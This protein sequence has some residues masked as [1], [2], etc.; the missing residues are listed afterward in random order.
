M[1]ATWEQPKKLK[2]ADIAK[3]HIFVVEKTRFTN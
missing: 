3:T 2:K 1:L